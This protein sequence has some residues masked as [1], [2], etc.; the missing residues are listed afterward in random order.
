M[1]Y[2]IRLLPTA[3]C[4]FI[5][6]YQHLDIDFMT[7]A[8]ITRAAGVRIGNVRPH[9]RWDEMDHAGTSA[10]LRGDARRRGKADAD[11]FPV[12]GGIEG[13]RRALE[14]KGFRADLARVIRGSGREEIP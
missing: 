2:C 6:Q 14:G 8:T 10:T 11:A 12:V 13:F 9:I 3:L 5:N 4:P 1:I 7:E